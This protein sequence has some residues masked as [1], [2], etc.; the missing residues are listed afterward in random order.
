MK[1]VR[2]TIAALSLMLCAATAVQAADIGKIKPQ[3][4]GNRAT[5][6]MS[7]LQSAGKSDTGVPLFVAEIHFGL[8]DKPD[9]SPEEGC[10][11]EN[12]DND[13]GVEYWLI[14]GE[15]PSLLVA[16]CNDGYGAAGVG[17][18]EVHIAPNRFTHMQD[19]GSNDRWENIDT[20]SL[21]P[22]HTLRSEFCGF[23]GT[24]PNY[25]VYGVID[26][27]HMAANELAI[28]D[29]IEINDNDDP[30]TRLKKRIGKPIGHGYLGGIAVPFAST[31]TGSINGN[32]LPENGTTLGSCASV[33][34]LDGKS[35]N[36]VFGKADPAR[37]AELRFVGDF[38]D[39][40]VQIYDPRR[41][42]GA[43]Q[44]W[45]N[46]DHLELWTTTV[47]GFSSHVDPKA[48]MQIGI[49]LDGEIHT[50][51][52]KPVLPTVERWEATDEQNRPVIV[53]K[54]HW[55]SQDELAAGLGI[56]YSQAEAGRQERIFATT[57]IVKNRPLFLPSVM[58]I[59][60][61]CSAVNGRWEVT[62]NPGRLEP[63]GE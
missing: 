20:I 38:Q 62:G 22:Q 11:T 58:V 55:P 6:R 46:T 9:A 24:E 48:A 21:S 14:D 39:L 34:K 43:P 61:S 63:Q 40:V 19:G 31:D 26:V 54:L 50:G 15:K 60:V 4:C 28:D 8:A 17:Y 53:L 57:Q 30:C 33:W 23:R 35:G 36:L 37:Q 27:A 10:H 51:L 18:D 1:P 45:V 12:G 47:E 59:P 3:I 25:G 52:G 42:H 16:L 2:L 44:S 7:G 56:A 13:G 29:T 41:D 5:C 32:A 49:D